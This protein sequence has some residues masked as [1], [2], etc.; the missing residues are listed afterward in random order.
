VCG[1]GFLS[2]GTD[3]IEHM[4]DTVLEDVLPPR[5]DEMQPGA[6][7]GAMLA[8]VEVGR[9]SAHD[10]VTVLGSM[11]RQISHLQAQLYATMAEIADR[12]DQFEYPDGTDL[13]WDAATVEIGTALHLTRRSA[14][15]E[16]GLAAGLRRLRRV[17]N[18]LLRGSI[19]RS[20]ARVIVEGTAHLDETTARRVVD[21]VIDDAATLTTGQLT[22]RLRR[23]C[24]EVDPDS[25]RDRYEETLQ[26]RRLV[27]EA[28]PSGTAHLLG[29]DLPPDRVMAIGERVDRLAASLRRAGDSRT[30][31]QLRADVYLDLLSGCQPDRRGGV[32]ELRVDLATLSGLSQAPGELAGYGP[33]IA[34]IARQVAEA[35]RGGEWRF[36]I[37]DPDTGLALHDGTTRRRPTAAQRRTVEARD[38]TCIF[39]GCRIPARR[40]DLDHRTRWSQHRSTCRA[41]L[42]A[43]CRY[44]HNTVRHRIGWTHQ[45]LPDG[46][47]LWTS[48]LGHR[49]TTSGRS[50]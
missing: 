29:L 38:R 46:D 9:L 12:A 34:D 28:S 13:G 40:C 1:C 44:H 17:W 30:M 4:F 5:I 32:V 48:P 26:Q 50:P 7:A 14:E 11:Q 23:C 42:D 25:A 37:T 18:A 31:D 8:A 27:V 49:Y 20:R 16:L 15:T 21:A 3:I 45:P 33:V 39:P 24:I 2:W 43:L 19:D 36:S 47:H 35:H 6:A 41:G 22:A 10:L